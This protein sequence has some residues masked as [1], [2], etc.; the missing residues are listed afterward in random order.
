VTRTVAGK[1]SIGELYVFVGGRGVVL[2]KKVWELNQKQIPTHFKAKPEK[3]VGTPFS[4]VLAPLY[5][6]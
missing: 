3:G 1:S 4:R 5:P 2:T 6:W